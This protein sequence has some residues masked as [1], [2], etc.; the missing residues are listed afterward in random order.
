MASLSVQHLLADDDLSFKDE[1]TQK[2]HFLHLYYVMAHKQLHNFD[3]KITDLHARKL[4]SDE[5]YLNLLALRTQIEEIEHEIAQVWKEDEKGKLGLKKKLALKQAIS[6]YASTSNIVAASLENLIH[7]LGLAHEN[8]KAA[9]L[10]LKEIVQEYARLESLKDFQILQK[11]I[12]HLAHVM[13]AKIDDKDQTFSP[14]SSKSGHFSGDEFP[15]KV[16]AITFDDGPTRTTLNILK[17]LKDKNI[18]ATF[19]QVASKVEEEHELARSISK[20]QMEVGAHSWNHVQLTKVGAITLHKEIHLATKKI[21]EIHGERISFYR[22]PYGAGISVNHIREKIAE[23]GLIHAGWN[24]D[25]LD[26]MPQSPDRIVTRTIKLMGK[27]S[28]DSGI[29]LLHDVHERTALALPRI[30]DYLKENNRRTCTLDQIVG[31]MNKA[32]PS[33]CSKN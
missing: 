20:A 8:K 22:L 24:V 7:D 11:N 9:Y 10:S 13:E 3:G 23:T 19:F 2:L 16:W 27:T 5:S 4:Y 30:L 21:E 26:W 32:S 28:K 14:S 18:Q 33:V 12:D 15:A 6:T 31:D 25:G 1:I 17:T 29:L